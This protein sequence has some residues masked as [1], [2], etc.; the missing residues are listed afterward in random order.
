MAPKA[1][2]GN[3]TMPAANRL[4]VRLED[5]SKTLERLAR[6][7]GRRIGIDKRLS[8]GLKVA[9]EIDP[10]ALGHGKKHPHDLRIELGSFETFDFFAR[11]G[12]GLRRPIR[13]IRSDG[14]QS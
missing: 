7:L 3:V 8:L 6:T 1:I 11:R 2:L 4:R 9:A 14:I 5:G 10:D 13:P 12:H